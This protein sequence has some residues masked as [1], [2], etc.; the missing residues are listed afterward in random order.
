MTV[1]GDLRFVKR[2]WKEQEGSQQGNPV[3]KSE[4]ASFT[5]KFTKHHLQRTECRVWTDKTD[6]KRQAAT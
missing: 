3:K 5:Q 6:S 1:T 2:L 4:A